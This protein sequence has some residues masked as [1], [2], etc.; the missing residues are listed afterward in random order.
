MHG[1]TKLIHRMIAVLVLFIMVG[2]YSLDCY[3]KESES[4]DS[5]NMIALTNEEIQY[6]ADHPTITIAMDTSW[7]PYCFYDESESEVAGILPNALKTITE[8]TGLDIQ[9]VPKNT[10][11]DALQAVQSGETSLVSGLANDPKAA[12]KNDILITEPYIT[13]HYSSVT[14]HQIT[15]LYAGGANYKVAVCKGSYSTM[16]MKEKMPSYTFVEYHNNAECMDAVQNDEVDMALVA[17]H[18]AEYYSA[19]HE[20]SGL[21]VQLINDF[22][23]GLSIGVNKNVDPMVIEILNKSIESIDTVELNQEVYNG[24]MDAYN[25][26]IRLSDWFYARPVIGVF[27]IV[28]FVVLILLII[29]LAIYHKHNRK[30]LNVT[31]NALEEARLADVAKTDFL[32]RMSH[33]MRTP[34]N[35]ILGLVELASPQDSKDELLHSLDKIGQSGQYLLGLIND[36]LDFQKIESGKLELNLEIVNCRNIFDN[37]IDMINKMAADK[38]VDFIITNR[39]TNLDWY[40]RVDALRI[41]QILMNLLSNAV[42][43]TP[44]GGVV[45]LEFECLGKDGMISHDV[46]HIRDNG[47]G[48]SEDFV[49]NKLFRPFMQETNEMSKYYAGSGL[50]LSIVKSL[51]ELMGGKIEVESKIGEGTTFT[52]YLDFERVDKK[53]A[54]EYSQE[55]MQ[56][57]GDS[58]EILNGKRILLVEDHP[59]N[60]EVARRILEKAGCHVCW[61]QD[62]KQA[63]DEFAAAA[64]YFYDAV[65]MDIRM[66]KMDGF[67]ATR[68]IRSSQKEDASTIPIIAMTANAFDTDR[69]ESLK[70]GMNAHLSKPIDQ[71]ILYHTLAEQIVKGSLESGRN[72]DRQR[73][74][75]L[76][77]DDVDINNVVMKS[78]LEP[79]YNVLIAKHGKDAIEWLQKRNDIVAVI[80]DIQMPV[81]DGIELI[82]YMRLH[83]EYRYIAILANTQYGEP[84]QEERLLELGAD[85]F[86]YKPLTP[87]IIRKRLE[88]VLQKYRF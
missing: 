25:A 82:K 81:M 72:I 22:T 62:G 17:T 68:H 84:E 3:A 16:A 6:I 40:I 58:T 35:G 70:A 53:E 9:F 20:Y 23:W 71:K 66:P 13:I 50:G 69:E 44:K 7:I 76:I 59:L 21:Y 86:I 11:A 83:E 47:V 19:K 45:E 64:A 49:Q 31:Q 67:E 39:N 77:V 14:K 10:Y 61:K 73:P 37:V 48:M 52:I 60:A 43:F 46:I 38:G 54:L 75:I 5:S 57:K 29:F 74:T 36:T 55:K 41:R 42:K 32:S 56:K 28:S 15:D 1:K 33:D 51:V 8:K 87:V 78:T 30:L 63:V 2:A 79:R 4:D 26:N 27:I 24:V 85:D 65:L 88:N 34:M 18:A 80:T 12:E